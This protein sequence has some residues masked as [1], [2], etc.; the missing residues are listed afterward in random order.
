MDKSEIFGKY[1]EMTYGHDISPEQTSQYGIRGYVS[2]DGMFYFVEWLGNLPFQR[3]RWVGFN[4]ISID[5]GRGSDGTRFVMLGTTAEGKINLPNLLRYMQYIE[6]YTAKL[7]KNADTMQKY[8][9]KLAF[10]I[11]NIAAHC[12]EGVPFQIKEDD[13]DTKR[14]R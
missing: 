11:H 7:I 14:E 9:R 6:R 12:L 1:S 8:E 5:F 4:I 2:N 13:Q 10:E 3:E